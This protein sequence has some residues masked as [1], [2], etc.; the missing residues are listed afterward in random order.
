MGLFVLAGVYVIILAGFFFLQVFLSKQEN[1]WLGLILPL[2]SLIFAVL[3]ILTVGYDNYYGLPV[4]LI[5]CI[6]LMP[7]A[8]LLTVYAAIRGKWRKRKA[9]DKMSARDLE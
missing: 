3:V 8:V 9:L 7:V 4:L 2:I 1:R 5:G 6:A